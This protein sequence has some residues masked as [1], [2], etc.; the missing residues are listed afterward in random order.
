M[1]VNYSPKFRTVNVEEFSKLLYFH[2]KAR[3]DLYNKLRE[4]E[5]N[6]V[7]LDK[8]ISLY[9]DHSYISEA[10]YKTFSKDN[11]KKMKATL[12]S[13]SPNEECPKDYRLFVDFMS[14]EAWKELK[15]MG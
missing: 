12:K 9:K 5:E 2:Y 3:Y 10:G 14:S 13:I 11:W 8:W 15:K 1:Q 4:N 6:E 7:L